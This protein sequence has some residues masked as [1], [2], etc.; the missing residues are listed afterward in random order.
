MANQ[1]DSSP[2]ELKTVTSNDSENNQGDSKEDI[3][4]NSLDTSPQ[5]KTTDYGIELSPEDKI[6]LLVQTTDSK[7]NDIQ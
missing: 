2:T 7:L 6:T 4:D 5:L 3:V 1:K